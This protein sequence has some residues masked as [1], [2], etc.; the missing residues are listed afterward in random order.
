MEKASSLSWRLP[1]FI[2]TEV[3]AFSD[4]IDSIFLAKLMNQSI[5]DLGE[6]FRTSLQQLNGEVNFPPVL[7]LSVH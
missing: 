6:F 5:D 3:N 2:I 7:N 4:A 1:S